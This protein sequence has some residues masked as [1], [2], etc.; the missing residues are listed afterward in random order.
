VK[1]K[2]SGGQ[3]TNGLSQRVIVMKTVDMAMALYFVSAFKDD[4]KY[5]GLQIIDFAHLINESMQ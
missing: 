1:H 5:H 4:Y 3:F 2:G